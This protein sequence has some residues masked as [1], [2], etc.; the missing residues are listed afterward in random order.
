M[1]DTRLGRAGRIVIGLCVAVTAL[2]VVGDSRRPAWTE[3]TARLVN[4]VTAEQARATR[5]EFGIDHLRPTRPDGTYW[6]SRWDAPRAFDGVD[7]R[8][9]WFDAA[10]GEGSYEAG[11]GQLL[12]S[13][14]TP[15]MYVHDPHLRR[16]WRDV[17]IT[18]YVKRIDDQ[19]IAY[20]GFTAVARANHLTT[21][22]GSADRCDT[23]GYGAR[24]RFDGHA[25]FEKETAHPENQAIANREIFAGGM[26][27]NTW[28][29]VKYVVFDRPDGVHLQLWLDRADG[30]GGGDW[31]LIDSV[32]DDGHLFGDVPCATGIDPSMELRGGSSRPGSESGRPNVSVYFRGDGIG[33]GGLAYK[34]GSV[35]EIVP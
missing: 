27:S 17:E 25:D 34:W 2:V 11:D 22:D 10:H 5:D 23:R 26:P 21:E 28:L 15:R 14:Q 9:P 20:S 13:G 35:R 4:Q 1:P 6:V 29:G 19:G 3:P 8:D 30:R 18:M 12:V 7:P 33:D 24:L 32:T 31:R 16:Q